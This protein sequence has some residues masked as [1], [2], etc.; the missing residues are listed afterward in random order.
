MTPVRQFVPNSN[1]AWEKRSSMHVTVC[2]YIGLWAW[3]GC[4]L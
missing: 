3:K 2:V 4:V 1:C